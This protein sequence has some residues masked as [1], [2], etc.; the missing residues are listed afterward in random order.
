MPP[1]VATRSSLEQVIV[2]DRLLRLSKPV[3]MAR[4]ETALQCC[5][6]TVR[7]HLKW[8]SK[9]LGARVQ[10]TDSGWRYEPGH[11]QL[12]SDYVRRR[13]CL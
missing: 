1:K 13:V 6:K 7:R 9:H 8:M 12:F 10:R 4:M 3:S 2:L 11:P 5:E